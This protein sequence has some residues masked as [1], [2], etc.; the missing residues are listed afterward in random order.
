MKNHSLI[1]HTSVKLGFVPAHIKLDGTHIPDEDGNLGR[2]EQG[3]LLLLEGIARTCELSPVKLDAIQVMSFPGIK[4]ADSDELFSGI[5]DLG[6]EPQLVIMVGGVDTMDPKDEDEAT[7][8]LLAGIEIA[9]RHQVKHVCSTSAEAWMAIPA[10]KDDDEYQARVAQNVRLHHRVYTEGDIANS[11]IESWSLEFLRPGEMNTFTSIPTIKPLISGLNSK[12]G[13]PFFKVLVDAAHCGDGDFSVEENVNFIQQLADDDELVVFHAST[14]TTRGCISTDDGWIAPLL[15]AA[16][17]TGKVKYL[18]T[19]IFHH[20]DP[21]LQ[22]LRDFDPRHGIDT[23]DG[24]GYCETV[25]ENLGEITHRLNN[26]KA[27]SLLD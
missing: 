8:Q 23:T 4:A 1:N 25:A 21:I 15:K 22:A 19:E 18:F 16:V 5:A 10:P 14:P 20:Q 7:A 12:V 24:R 27:R 2:N 26:L 3:Q 17:T 6:L 13:S 11:T 9:K